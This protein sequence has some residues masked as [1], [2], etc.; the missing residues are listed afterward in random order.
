[1]SVAGIVVRDDGRVLAVQRRD[2][3]RWEPPGG[4][5]ERGETFAAGVRREVA[6]ETGIDVRVD[7]LSGAYLNQPR[8]IVALVFRCTHT[9]GTPM[10]TDE[11]QRVEW[12]APADVERLMVPAFAVRVRDALGTGATFRAHDGFRVVDP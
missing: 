9:S 6:E 12:L 11:A 7:R 8:D 10:T 3:A 2:N 1:V 4:V 5:L